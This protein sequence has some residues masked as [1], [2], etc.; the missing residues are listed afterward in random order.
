VVPGLTGEAWR[1]D[2]FSSR[3]E[4]TWPEGRRNDGFTL[5]FW[6][7]LEAYPADLEV[8]PRDLTPGSLARLRDDDLG[9]DIIVDAY[10]RWG[11]DVLTERGMRTLRVEERFPERAWA[12]VS[13]THR[14]ADQKIELAL[15]G[16]VVVSAEIPDFKLPKDRPLVLAQ[17][18]KN[19]EFLVFT[20]NGI[21]GS[22]DDLTITEP[23]SPA[24]IAETFAVNQSRL[25]TSDVALQ[26]PASRFAADHLRPKIHAMPPANWTNEPHGLVRKDGR[27]HLFYQRTPNGPFKTLMHW[28]H[29]SSDNLIHWRHHPDALKPE[30]QTEDFGF[31]QKGI[32]SGDVIVDGDKAFAFYTSVNHFH[33]LTAANPGISMAVAA[34]NDLDEWKK[35]GPVI[36]S[37]EVNDFRDPYLWREADTWHMIIGASLDTG[38]GLA[39]YTLDR[40]ENTAKWT[41]KKRFTTLSYRILDPGSD[42]WEMPV[43]EPIGQGKHILVVNP[44]GGEVTKYGTPGTRGVYWTGRWDGV[45]FKPDYKRP[46]NLDVLVGHLSPTVARGDD[47]DLRAIGIIDERRTPQAQ[48]DAGWAHTFSLPRRWFLMPNGET[49][50]QAP[51]PELLDL[52]DGEPLISKP[53][54]LNDELV[55]LGGESGHYELEITDLEGACVSIS[56]GASADLTEQSILTIDGSTGDVKFSRGQSNLARTNEGPD[57]VSDRYSIEDFGS[58]ET[59]RMFHDGS[60]TDFFINDAAAFGLRIYPSRADSKSVSITSCGEGGQVVNVSKW[61]LG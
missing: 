14:P 47:G 48:E 2:G 58:L 6:V 37:R 38:G 57:K 46:K 24:A 7:I 61:Q 27:W 43:F 29:M 59:L 3:A 30:L 41:Y 21:N 17:P 34:D 15:D 53:V 31:D 25:P 51:A 32:W 8:L 50:G 22:Y 16:E 11:V 5:S 10:G 26:V 45:R 44:I 42:I 12:L 54:S 60:V 18:F 4:F 56:W 9:F 40:G 35:L 55:S 33:R 36:D 28:G 19:V 23:L 1:T 49:L 13:L 20:F 39:Y 52:R